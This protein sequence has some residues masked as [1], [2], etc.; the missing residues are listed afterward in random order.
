MAVKISENNFDLI[1]LFAA[2]Q[3]A[4]LHVIGYASPNLSDSLLA[5]LLDLF[6]G[7]PIFFFISGFLISR[8]Y[9]KTNTVID[10]SR[11][12]ALRIYPALHIC[13]TLNL[14]AV[15]L[16]GYFSS[17]NTSLI[18]ILTLY[19]AK[20]TFLQFYNPDFMRGFG[21]GVLNGSL[22]TICVELQFYFL[23]PVIFK[24]FYSGS[25]TRKKFNLFITIIISIIFNRLLYN[26]MPEYG[27]TT[28]WK[29]LRVSFLPWLYMFLCGAFVQI[30]FDYFSRFLNK[31]A[32]LFAIPAYIVFA[33]FMQNRG[34]SLSNS[35]S[36]V[37]FFPLAAL[38]LITAFSAPSLARK[39]LR[40]HDISYGIYIYHV[41]VMNMFLFYKLIGSGWYTA[42][43]LT[44]SIFLAL[45][46]WFIIERP[47][48]QLKRK[49]THPIAPEPS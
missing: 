20:T 27:S 12:R 17:N 9:E 46:S 29:L 10:Y 14:V 2:S 40:G 43:I 11:N 15:A 19:L 31:R 35:V 30:N 28:S 8:S 18:D 38:I 37:I 36:P 45:C 23:T 16:T 49:A 48:L 32:I 13:V 33:A 1:R 3:V 6:P 34:Y 47:C 41:P 26:T 5:K 39:L 24:L 22:W 4:I 42:S 21:D 7:V 25:S 44:V